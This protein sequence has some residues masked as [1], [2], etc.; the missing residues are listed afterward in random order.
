MS[1]R[2]SEDEYSDNE[3][4]D[5]DE[6]I[7][8]YSQF[9]SP[10]LASLLK[11]DSLSALAAS[12]PA[13]GF[14]LVGTQAGILHILDARDG[15]HIK[16]TRP[17][18][19]TITALSVEGG[20]VASSSIDGRVILQQLPHSP[21][22]EHDPTLDDKD[23]G[24]VGVDFKRPMLAVSV[25]PAAA[26]GQPPPFIAGGLKGELTLHTPSTFPSLSTL[27]FG[28]AGGSGGAGYSKEIVHSSEGPIWATKWSPS[29][30]LVAWANDKVSF[31]RSIIHKH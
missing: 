17:H 19:A 31:C 13:T 8:K 12:D 7:L 21:H 30:G 9:S 23:I 10:V 3:S 4:D 26:Q 27:T 18:S 24:P 20:W 28:L 16:S 6:P 29:G 25:S 15:T 5:E 22:S 14:I 11:S 2:E 1:A